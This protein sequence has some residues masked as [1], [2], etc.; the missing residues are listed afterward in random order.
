MNERMRNSNKSERQQGHNYV[1]RLNESM[2]DWNERRLIGL[3]C[4][5]EGCCNS[6]VSACAPSEHKYSG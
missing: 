2:I 5:Y 3:V 4:R 6:G 1:W